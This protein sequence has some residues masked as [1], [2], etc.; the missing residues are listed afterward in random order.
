MTQYTKCF[1]H[2]VD[3]WNAEL[4]LK[5]PAH[6][7]QMAD[8]L[9]KVVS[10]P[11]RR[12]LLLAFRGGGK[13]SLVGLFLAWLLRKNPDMRVLVISADE[14]L[15]KKMVKNT[16]RIIELHPQT[17]DLVP[18]GRKE[19]WA[20]TSFTIE[21]PGTLR[22]PS[23]SAIGLG[24]NATGNRAD[25]IVCDDVEVPRNSDTRA[26]REDLREKLT[27]LQFVLSPNGAQIFIGTP[28]TKDT[29]YKVG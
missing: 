27:E 3:E 11:P 16:R 23:V 9:E 21:R 20:G 22:D 7:T 19:Q 13:S 15:A 8:W 5:T 6:H 26:K 29:I 24:G 28:H 12:G 4:S 14:R 1:R 17:K 2:F 10:T 25:V 18:K